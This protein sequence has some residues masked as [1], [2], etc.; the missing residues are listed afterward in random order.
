[1]RTLVTAAS[2]HGSTTEIAAVLADTLR[3]NGVEVDLAAPG[4]VHEL[5]GYDTIILGS[6][7]YFGR[8]MKEAEDFAERFS[9]ALRIRQA[10]L[11]SSGPIG[12]DNCSDGVPTDVTSLLE[13]T[14]AVEHRS[15]S[16]K[17]DRRVLGLGEKLASRIVHP[18]EGDFRNRNSVRGWAE[19]ILD[20]PRQTRHLEPEGRS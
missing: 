20:T 19:S 10:W 11:F 9:D 14:G 18:P 12:P 16:G 1:M 7:I 8:W 5:T 17:L 2:R 6:A 3:S 13:K 15:F 4:V